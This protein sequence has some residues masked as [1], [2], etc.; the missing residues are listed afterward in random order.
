MPLLTPTTAPQYTVYIYILHTDMTSPYKHW[1]VFDTQWKDSK[2]EE[3]VGEK[4]EI[5][6]NYHDNYAQ[7]CRCMSPISDTQD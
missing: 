4:Q 3:T 5:I 7:D 2:M 1:I 6:V